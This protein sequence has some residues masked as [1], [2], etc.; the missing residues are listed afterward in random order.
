MKVSLERL[1]D[2]DSSLQPFV[3]LDVPLKA[4]PADGRGRPEAKLAEE[5]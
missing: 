4:S 1:D 3:V 2:A 5:L